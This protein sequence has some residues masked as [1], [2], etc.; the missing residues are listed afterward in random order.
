MHQ[1]NAANAVLLNISEY[2]FMNNLS[3]SKTII[4]LAVS[5]PAHHSSALPSANIH[6][7]SGEL[8]QVSRVAYF[9]L[10]ELIFRQMIRLSILIACLPGF[11]PGTKGRT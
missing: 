9:F 4:M 2:V 1:F 7:V 3:Q 6:K 10:A 5:P 11:K 8:N